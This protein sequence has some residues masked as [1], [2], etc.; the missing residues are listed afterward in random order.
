M[1][2]FLL[3]KS[4]SCLWE[5]RICVEHEISALEARVVT[6]RVT[7][8][9]VASKPCARPTDYDSVLYDNGRNSRALIGQTSLSIGKQTHEFIIC[10][11]RQR[12]KADN[13]TICYRKNKLTSVFHESALLLTMDFVIDDVTTKFMITNRIDA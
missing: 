10:A 9:S 12:A 6:A 5:W 13:L 7:L 3:S 2:I 4:S 8:F 11:M 1:F